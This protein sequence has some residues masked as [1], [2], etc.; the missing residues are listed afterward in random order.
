[1]RKV[2]TYNILYARST[3]NGWATINAYSK[4]EAASLFLEYVQSDVQI[5]RVELKAYNGFPYQYIMFEGSVI[6]PANGHD[7]IIK[8]S[9]Y[10]VPDGSIIEKIMQDYDGNW[11]DGVVMND[12]VW[13]ASN[14]KCT[15]LPDGTTI[16]LTDSPA[17]MTSESFYRYN[18]QGT[19][20]TP[21]GD[22]SLVNECG[23]L[24]NFAA[25]TRGASYDA[26]T[27]VPVQG[28]YPDGWHVPNKKEFDDLFEY[29]GTISKYYYG[30][31]AYI[32]KAMAGKYLWEE[33]ENT[34]GVLGNDLHSNNNSNFN[35][36]PSNK[37][38]T[39]LYSVIASSSLGISGSVYYCLDIE[40][41]RP[42]VRVIEL[43]SLATT[44]G[45][46]T[47]GVL[48]ESASDYIKKHFSRLYIKATT[49]GYV[50]SRLSEVAETGN[51]NDLTNKPEN[52]SLFKNDI[53]YITAADV[54]AINNGALIIKQ[55]NVIIN[56]FYANQANDTTINLPQHTFIEYFS[57]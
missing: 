16:T 39:H 40:Q 37:A 14:F 47:R 45:M 44:Y 20:T 5:R 21:Q 27:G 23:Y 54:P 24:Y 6:Y 36:L 13:L 42:D 11:Y 48:N 15:H 53:G 12:K 18:P 1:M 30:N 34:G 43:G 46:A 28:I 56:K 8:V 50:Y 51:Y 57:E 55:G 10:K 52:V 49:G 9:G 32:A 7:D 2:S 3:G 31:A 41:G 19:S 4:Q 26:E 29:M 25:I 38:A 17:N 35:I 33:S 22:S